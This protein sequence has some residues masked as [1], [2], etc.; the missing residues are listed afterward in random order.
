MVGPQPSKRRLGVALGLA[1]SLI[2]AQ[3][4][5]D[6]VTLVPSRDSTIYSEKA[7]LSNGAGE[8]L[9]AGRTGLSAS[10]RALIAFDVAAGIPAGSK[11]TRVTLTLHVSQSPFVN[12]RAP[13][14]EPLAIHRVSAAWGQGVSNAGFPGGLGTP[15]ADSDTTWTH[16][17][18]STGDTWTRAGGDFVA[19]ASA[20][21]V[22]PVTNDG[23]VTWG[24][25]PEMVADVQ[26]W[27]DSPASNFGWILIGNEAADKTA[28]RLDSRE[29]REAK[30][31]PVLTIEYTPP[32]R[33]SR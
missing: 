11:I 26:Q 10:R 13:L 24:S 28:R 21:T 5:A 27:A 4:R 15:A 1:V 6:V 31:R 14:P 17:F 23:F 2:A 8:F 7:D 32:I 3:A 25:T 9:F 18:W 12:S 20:S 29:N 33:P 22:V 16:R 30:Y 19:T